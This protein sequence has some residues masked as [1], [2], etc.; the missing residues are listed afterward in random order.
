[1][2]VSRF[3]YPLDKGDKLRAYH[4]LNE[5]NK[6]FDVSLVAL[7]DSKVSDANFSKVNEICDELIILKINSWTKI[8]NMISCLFGSK[9]IQ[10]GYFY[11]KTAQKKINEVITQGDFQH[12][13]CQLIRTSEYIKNYHHIPKTIDYMD[14]LSMGIERRIK[15]Q[16]FY[17]KWLF[18]LEARRLKKYE[19]Y[20][21]DY[22]ENHTI[23]SEQDKQLINHPERERIICTPNG[24]DSSFF[25]KINGTREFDFIFVGN[26][27]YA[28]NVEAV[29][30][31]AKEILPR[32][33]NSTLLI[34]G[35]SPNSS[36]KKIA[37]QN[38]NIK[39]TGWVDDIR[40][41]YVMGEIFLAPMT[42]GTGMQNKLL[43][44]M[45]IGTPCVTTPLANN[46]INA[47]NREEIMVGA[48]TE[49]LISHIEELKSD[50]AL[51]SKISTN[52]SEL[53]R[54][55]FSWEKSIVRL[56]EIIKKI[57]SSI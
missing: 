52:A 6:H 31:I 34:S 9:P 10:V 33:P 12:I 24:I 7:T 42:I 41:S 11:S 18:K 36:I 40:T 13:Y 27:S 47:K 25:E 57:G 20:I 54:T 56:I 2:L 48:T 26:M 39:I 53:V 5:L 55:K 14:A 17:K 50:H 46:A 1:M 21:F 16:V 43:E 3:P 44:A 8:F 22:F 49:E 32:I 28:P 51:Y 15:L 4:Q 45:A 30:L 37:E 38:K 19:Q 35:S 23:I 29:H